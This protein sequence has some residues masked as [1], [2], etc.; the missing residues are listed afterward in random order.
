MADE[1][2][3]Q[4]PAS[5]PGG[6]EQTGESGGGPYPNPH[7]GQEKPDFKG[8]SSDHGYYGKGGVDDDTGDRN[9]NAASQES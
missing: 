1:H 8:G 2:E 6:P 7:S 9:D 4:A 3:K 5:R